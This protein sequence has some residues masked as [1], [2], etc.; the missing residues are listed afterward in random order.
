MT[1]LEIIVWGCA[2]LFWGLAAV[3]VAVYL[4]VSWRSRWTW[5]RS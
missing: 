4:F 2:V 3:F 1:P 5:R